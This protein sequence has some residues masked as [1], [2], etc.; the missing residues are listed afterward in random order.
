MLKFHRGER[1]Y[2]TERLKKKRKGYWGYPSSVSY[3]TEPPVQMTPFQ[4]GVVVQNPVV[5]TCW[6][7]SGSA[8]RKMCGNGKDGLTFQELKNL[9]KD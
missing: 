6:M 1:R 5:H 9:Y 4:L 7:C 8:L 2:Q 3:P